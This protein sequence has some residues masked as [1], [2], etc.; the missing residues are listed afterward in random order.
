MSI[1]AAVLGRSSRERRE[2]RT[3]A[4]AK[5]WK[6]VIVRSGDVTLRRRAGANSLAVIEAETRI[7]NDARPRQQPKRFAR[8]DSAAT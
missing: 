4:A 6:S 7:A 3:S 8:D 2:L 1:D 5:P